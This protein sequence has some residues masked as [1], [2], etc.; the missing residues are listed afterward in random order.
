VQ[1]ARYIFLAA[2][3][4]GV[5]Y[6][7]DSTGVDD[8]FYLNSLMKHGGA[9]PKPNVPDSGKNEVSS[10]AMQQG[11]PWQKLQKS[12]LFR[13]T[14]GKTA[15][16]RSRDYMVK[17]FVDDKNF[18]EVQVLW[19]SAFKY[20]DFYSTG[21][22]TYLDTLLT[23]EGRKQ[24][25][26][27][28]GHFN[29]L[30]M[31]SLHFSVK[32]DE[33]NY[34]LRVYVPPEIKALQ[35]TR[36]GREYV[37]RGSLLEPAWFSFYMNMRTA[38][39]FNCSEHL[40]TGEAGSDWDSGSPCMRQ[41]VNLDLDGA[42]ASL[43][44]VL[45]GSGIV[46]E[47]QQ[48]Q[49]FGKNN[50]R[51]YDFRLVRDIYSAKSRLSLGDVSGSG[52]LSSGTL[53]GVKYE[54]NKRFFSNSILSEQYKI[55]FTLPR[56]AQ[57]EV[58][59]NGNAAQRISLPAGSHELSGFS[60]HRGLNAV[61]VFMT[62]EDGTFEAIPYEFELGGSSNLLKG[63]VAYSVTAGV[64]R[65]SAPMGYDYNVKEPAA[66]ADV[67]Y[68][69]TPF[70]TGG[71]SAQASM[72]NAIMGTRFLLSADSLSWWEFRAL[73]NYADSSKFGHTEEFKYTRMAQNASLSLMGYHKSRAY[74][75]HLFT[76]LPFPNADLFGVSSTA[77]LGIPRGGI[78]VSAGVS[79][80][81]LQGGGR[82][83]LNYNYGAGLSQT[84]L[85][86]SL[87][88]SA[89]A[90]V[91]NRELE[92]Y[93]SF[94]ANY[95]FGVD[96]HNFTILDEISYNP[97]YVMP[98]Y[99]FETTTDSSSLGVSIEPEFEEETPGYTKYEWQNLFSLGWSWSDGGS[100]NGARSYSADISTQSNY[101]SGRLWGQHTYNR[102]K[103]SAGYGLTDINMG[104]TTTR[105]HSANASL[106][107]SFMFADGLWA[108][109]RP[110]DRGFILA[111]VR[112]GLTGATV[113]INHSEFFNSDYSESGWLGAAYYNQTM[114]YR[115][116]EIQVTLTD[117]PVGS[118]L[119]QDRYYTMGA[120]KQ[121][122]AVRLGSEALALL[123]VRLID[124][125]GPFAYKYV[126][127]EHLDSKG[128][129][130]D[131]RA[132]FT[133]KEGILQSGN[134]HPGHKYRLNFGEDSYLKNIE[135]DIPRGAGSL[136]IL[137]DIRVEHKSAE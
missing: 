132:T 44:W 12:D 40:Y 131:K 108:F 107:A 98:T 84:I 34:E 94:G 14:F 4:W 104:N 101:N 27:L 100:N 52:I 127:V 19:D 76:K 25:N 118:W 133:S 117:I 67:L 91:R 16:P 135:I 89:S 90:I 116:N 86:I 70:L 29:S 59:I 41:P 36:L 109:G 10:R 56:P 60:G 7:Q 73:A 24:T 80:N 83:P 50:A 2:L 125:S 17:L 124:E 21:F 35:R 49:K 126:T 37:P 119:E 121:G 69:I 128:V 82:S 63:E 122:Y 93:I 22:S 120:Y 65:S 106:G 5:A 78:S 11:V 87:N 64:N 61:E 26:G 55:R 47:P 54:H 6:S 13:L 79:M 113:H 103:I 105:G 48:G 102:A 95:I 112:N 99:S 45:E 3:L 43:G 66:N 97:V 96:R 137:P 33:N 115:P 72:Q 77:G 39:Y 134:I 85:D 92:P 42:F 32:L 111:N 74:N 88:A 123:Q 8:Y 28:D 9:P 114:N 129:V 30:R 1:V 15:P 53:G 75:P 136:I 57:V 58:Q 46:H 71:L 81:R 31:D 51:R 110:V 18:G 130:V 23:P 38:Q 68:G 62:Q 20:F